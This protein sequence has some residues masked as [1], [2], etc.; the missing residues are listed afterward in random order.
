MMAY[1][2][3]WMQVFSTQGLEYYQLGTYPTLEECQMELAK[4]TKIITHKSETVTC[5]EVEI[6]E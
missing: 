6:Q 2:L 5:L 1:I 3:I 4:A